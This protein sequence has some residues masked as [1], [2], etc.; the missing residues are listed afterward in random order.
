MW[1]ALGVTQLRGEVEGGLRAAWLRKKERKSTREE[2]EEGETLGT[3]LRSVATRRA[4]AR[5]ARRE[6]Q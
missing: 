3:A 5:S 1:D 4:R 2:E 6:R